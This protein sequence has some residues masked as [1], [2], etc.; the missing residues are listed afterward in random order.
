MEGQ[1]LHIIAF[2][3]PYP[4]N[5]GGIVDV[6]Y[7]LKHLHKAGVKITYHC[8]FYHG[9]NPPNKELEKYCE[10]VYYYERKKSIQKAMFG[11]LPYVVSSRND[12]ELLHN[13]IQ[14]DH[15]I[16]FD[17]IQCCY[18]LNNP[19]LSHRIRIYRA[20]NIEHEYYAGLA[21]WER[22]FFK[23]IYLKKE[24]RRLRKF[25]HELEG[26]D[27]ILS[28]AKMDIPHF[29]QYAETFHIPP[30]FKSDFSVSQL[31]IGGIKGKYILFQGN[32]SVMENE[33]AVRFMLRSIVPSID[34]NFVIAGK[35]PSQE[36]K[37]EIKLASNVVLV[38]SPPTVTMEGLIQNAHIN[39][40][41][42]FQ[43]TGIKLKLLHALESGKHI[44]INSLMDDSGIFAE[45]CHVHDDPEE[46]INKINELMDA[47]FTEE[48]RSKRREIFQKYFDNDHNAERI[49]E[50]I[51]E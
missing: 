47:S 17:G 26:V 18:F 6:F 1:Y 5:Y 46:I 2:D 8:F 49:L 12:E 38:D 29:E 30:F 28:V 14:D 32:L 4:P 11:K 16:L 19:L 10:K 20:N 42:T 24:T 15:P 39:L 34:A 37:N 13:L 50:I 9:H 43:Q 45:M 36:L 51:K 41:M 33:H 44:I 3:V 25:E 7:K 40:L 21:K 23:R 35:S 27:A 31:N 22:N 48:E